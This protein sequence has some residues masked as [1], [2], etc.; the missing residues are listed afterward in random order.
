MLIA[1]MFSNCNKEKL[2]IGGI[3]R[4]KYSE[5]NPTSV[6]INGYNTMV[7]VRP[8]DYY[9]IVKT[10][11]GTYRVEVSRCIYDATEIGD[12]LA[13]TTSRAVLIK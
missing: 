6:V 12:S 5:R 2:N 3:V 13:M 8:T 9:C 1:M 10:D 11:S 4:N 7:I